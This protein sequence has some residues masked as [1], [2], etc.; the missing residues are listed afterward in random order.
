MFRKYLL[1]LRGLELLLDLDLERRDARGLTGLTFSCLI[2][3]LGSRSG[4]SLRLCRF[5]FVILNKMYT[6][7]SLL[8]E[9]RSTFHLV[10]CSRAN[11]YLNSTATMVH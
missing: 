8:T 3:T 11:R 6:R 1:R 9:Y 7:L 10:N 2:L 4:D 5:S